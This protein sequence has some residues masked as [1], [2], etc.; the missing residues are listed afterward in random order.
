MKNIDVLL[1]GLSQYGT[2]YA[3]ALLEKGAAAS[4]R[5]VGIAD[6][7]AEK[8]AYYS[9]LREKAIPRFDTPEEFFAGRRADLA[10]IASP[11]HLHCRQTLAALRAGCHVLCEKPIA[12][13]IQEAREMIT[14]RDQSGKFVAI[15]YNWSFNR[16]IQDFKRDAMAG[17][18]GKPLRAKTIVLW[19]R[20]LDYF[21]RN[22]WAGKLRMP[23]GSWVL[24]SPVNNATA[25]YLHNMFYSLG[26]RTDRSLMPETVSAELYRANAIENYDTAC[27]RARTKEGVEIMYFTSH[28]L[29]QSMP[30]T[31]EF[32]FENA[33]VTMQEGLG[34][35]ARVR[36]G[37][38]LTYAWPAP[39]GHM[40]KLWQCIEAVRS[41]AQPA[42]GL[43]AGMAQTL[44]MNGAQESPVEIAS[45]PAGMVRREHA[46]KQGKELE[47]V[48]ADGLAGALQ[49]C[50]ESWQLPSEQKLPWARAGREVALRDYRHFPGGK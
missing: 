20:G 17:L 34:C 26:S 50:Y 22:N 2:G 28:A 42:C 5:L 32:V 10:V 39:T 19:A 12:G 18:F 7:Y 13:T 46:V 36:D 27:L 14:G 15:G 9:T 48:V 38:V 33:T 25:H 23:D 43:E 41:G 11:I 1:I 6:P 31:G 4:A 29:S 45:F 49:K 16:E 8:N 37:R 47:Y 44:C 35:T 24:D 21:N 30:I 3:R 40:D